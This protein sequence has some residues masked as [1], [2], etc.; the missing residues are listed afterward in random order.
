MFRK[1]YSLET[2]KK[3]LRN[4]CVHRGWKDPIER[5]FFLIQGGK[6]VG[7]ECIYTVYSPRVDLLFAHNAAKLRTRGSW[8][9]L[10]LLAARYLPEELVESKER[11]KRDQI[12]DVKSSGWHKHNSKWILLLVK[13]SACS[14][15]CHIYLVTICQCSQL[16]F[17][18]PEWPKK[19]YYRFKTWENHFLN[20]TRHHTSTPPP[21]ATILGPVLN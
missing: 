16:V 5:V 12:L 8:W 15:V 20:K 6:F 3:R 9:I 2:S 18:A 7:V 21:A 19:N 13:A 11:A 14:Q 4:A 17:A 10:E 1:Q